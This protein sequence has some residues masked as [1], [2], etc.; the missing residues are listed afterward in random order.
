MK[1]VQSTSMTS[2]LYKIL[3]SH[4]CSFVSVRKQIEQLITFR[5]PVKISETDLEERFIRGWGKGG[6]NVNKCNNAVY[7]KHIPSG[8]EIKVISLFFII[9]LFTLVS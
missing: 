9:F 8:I 5:K 6:Q 2:R 4:H 1:R 3:F 7:L